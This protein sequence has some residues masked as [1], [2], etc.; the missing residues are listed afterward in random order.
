MSE[1]SATTRTVRGSRATT[2]GFKTSRPVK[3]PIDPRF[4][5]ASGL[6]FEPD[7]DLL[8]GLGKKP[9]GKEQSETL[10]PG[11]MHARILTRAACFQVFTGWRRYHRVDGPRRY[12]KILTDKRHHLFAL[13][14]SPLTLSS[15]LFCIADRTS[16]D[17]PCTH[18]PRRLC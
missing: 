9:E 6:E 4:I 7:D 2:C 8:R 16:C 12:V 14:A 1:S 18:L 10:M 11:T 5:S 17:T 13:S 3:G 15:I